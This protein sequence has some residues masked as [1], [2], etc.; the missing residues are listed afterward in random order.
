MN[1]KRLSLPLAL[2]AYLGL[3]VWS[4]AEVI[5]QI[6]AQVNNEI[7]TLTEY[8]REKANLYREMSGRFKGEELKQRF[9]E[10]VKRIL[11]AM[12]DE[13]LLNQKAKE[14]GMDADLELEA[15]AYLEETMKQH[16]IPNLEALKEEMSRSGVNF[17]DYYSQMQQMILSNRIKGAIVRQRVKIM[18]AEVEQYYRDH[19]AEF[20]Q[21]E[22][23]DLQ[24]I[25]LYTKDKDPA[26]VREGIA[27]IYNE[28]KN[29]QSFDDLAKTFSEG[30]TAAEGGKIGVFSINTLSPVISAAIRDLEPGTYTGVLQLDFGFEIIKVLGKTASVQRQFSDVSKDI[31]DILFRKRLDPVI[32]DYLKEIRS[33]SYINVFPEFLA[34]YNAAMESEK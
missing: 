15:N 6:V 16:N 34:D 11:P 21:P 2:C 7:I 26:R 12:I 28:L 5:E 14:H 24:E 1:L 25:V 3:A 8:N 20:S 19:M 22:Q 27:G 18:S 17:N 32:K 23:Y 33:Q 13:L 29:G 4:P 30:P 9:D 31:E 10:L